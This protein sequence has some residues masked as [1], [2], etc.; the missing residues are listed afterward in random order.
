MMMSFRNNWKENSFTL[1]VIGMIQAL[2]L[3]P[4][5]I[6]TYAGGTSVDPNSLGFSLLYNF[7]SDLGRMT[8]YSGVPNRVSSFTF[9]VS[10]F[11]TG[12][13][14][15]PYFIA[16]PRLFKGEKL[17]FVFSVLGSIIGVFFALT[18]VG[19]ALTPSDLFMETHLM[20]G[21]LAFVSGLPIVVFH[22][23][24]ILGSQSYPNRYAGIYVALGLVL[25]LFLYSMYQ[26]GSVGL[27]LAV[28][29][30]QK[31]VVV[32]ILLCFLLQSLV[33]RNIVR[34]SKGYS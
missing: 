31:F 1:C 13:L 26:A 3:L 18:F 14:L 29:I 11:F 17:Q 16:F 5:A 20:F 33:A 6:L 28:T 12:V 2:L 21:A 7:F 9:N 15:V 10:L 19:G 24:A 25:S 23:S 30:G 22:T 32:S 4:I 34:T 27:S 8:A